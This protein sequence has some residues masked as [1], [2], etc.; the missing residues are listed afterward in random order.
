MDKLMFSLSEDDIYYYLKGKNS[1]CYNGNFFELDDVG[2]R[3]LAHYIYIN[4]P[5]ECDLYDSVMNN[6]DVEEVRCYYRDEYK[7]YDKVEELFGRD[8]SRDMVDDYILE[9]LDVG[10]NSIE[11]HLR[12][13]ENH[14]YIFTLNQVMYSYPCEE[15]LKTVD[16]FKEYYSNEINNANLYDGSISTLMWI[17]EDILTSEIQERN[18]CIFTPLPNG[19]YLWI[20]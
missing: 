20:D 3:K 15:Y 7:L 12:Y 19:N 11:T 16:K 18:Y 9:F 17:F 1:E 6:E 8:I 5:L 10:D 13:I 2:L 4:Q 14:I